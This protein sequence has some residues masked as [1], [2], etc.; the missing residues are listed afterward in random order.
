MVDG[1]GKAIEAALKEALALPDGA[2]TEMGRR[3]A[4]L[5]ERKYMGPAIGRQVYDEYRS[6]L[7]LRAE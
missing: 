1:A 6:L 7:S 3:G 5:A 4:A 2:R